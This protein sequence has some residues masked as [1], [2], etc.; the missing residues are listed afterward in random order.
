MVSLQYMALDAHIKT[1]VKYDGNN[2]VIENVLFE[3]DQLKDSLKIEI[4]DLVEEYKL[5]Q[6]IKNKEVLKLSEKFEKIMSEISKELFD[7]FTYAD[8]I[9]TFEDVEWKEYFHCVYDIVIPDETSTFNPRAW[10]TL[11]DPPEE[12]DTNSDSWSIV[13]SIKRKFDALKVE[14]DKLSNVNDILESQK[15]LGKEMLILKKEIAAKNE[16]LEIYYR[17][18]EWSMH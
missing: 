16:V 17:I 1:G 9:N 10:E 12:L 11:P 4:D 3:V 7:E 13:N 18:I 6:K 2:I 14:G 5:L 15:Q 8:S